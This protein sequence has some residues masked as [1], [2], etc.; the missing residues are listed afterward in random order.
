MNNGSGFEYCGK[1]TCRNTFKTKES[2]FFRQC[3]LHYCK[4]CSQHAV[5]HRPVSN[6]KNMGSASRQIAETEESDL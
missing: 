4:R 2:T 5:G 3:K 6:E 1:T